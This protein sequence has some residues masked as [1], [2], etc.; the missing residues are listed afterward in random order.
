MDAIQPISNFP[1]PSY[2]NEG[3]PFEMRQISNEVG[4]QQTEYYG[5]QIVLDLLVWSGVS[6]LL[7]LGSKRILLKARPRKS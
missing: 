5:S 6:F 4:Y 1:V 3:F 7:L 2:I